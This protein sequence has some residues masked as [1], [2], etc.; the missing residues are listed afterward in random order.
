MGKPKSDGRFPLTSCHDAPPSSLRMTSQCFCMNSTPGR[1][2]CMAMRCTQWP[3][4]AVGLGICSDLRPRLIGRH[5]LPASSLRK[6]P[7]DEMAMTIRFG[8]RGSKRI[9]CRHIPRLPGLP[10]VVGALDQLPEPA[11]ALRRVEAV[12]IGGRSLQMVHL[13]AAEVRP[14]DVPPVALP[15]RLEDE[16]ALPC[17]DQ[18]PYPAHPSLLLRRHEFGETLQAPGPAALMRIA[19][20]DRLEDGL[21]QRELRLPLMLGQRDGHQRLV[22]GFAFRV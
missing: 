12:G 7:A 10:A 19:L 1:E 16:R 3:T 6:A 15:V 2:G 9:V 5:V 21:M 14:G 8:S 18:Y 20:G 4:S 13:P 17:T 22:D 11:R